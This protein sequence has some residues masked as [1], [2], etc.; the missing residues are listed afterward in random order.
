VRPEFLDLLACP[1]C[2]G[3][4]TL[5]ATHWEEE[6]AMAGELPC[7]GCG[8]RF[9]LTG[10]VPRLGLERTAGTEVRANTARRFAFEWNRFSTFELAEEIASMATWLLPHQPSDLS[11]RTVLDAGCGMGRHMVIA[12]H[13]GAE[14]VVGLDLGDAVDAAFANTRHL[15]GTCVVQGDIYHPPLRDGAFDAAYSLGVLHHL[16][17]P[18]RGFAALAPKVRAGGFFQ[19]WVYGR[20]GNA[21]IVFLLNPIRRLTSRLPLPVLEK[22]CWLAS[23]PLFVALRT[24]YRI[25]RLGQRLPYGGYLTW[26]APFSLR[27]IHAI[28]FDHALAPVAHY[29]TRAEAVAMVADDDWEAP[30]LVHSRGMSWGVGVRRRAEGESGPASGP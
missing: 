11:G 28:V 20:E 7:H 16:P 22:L 6:H 14:R 23:A 8:R 2:S 18:E 10:G 4:L 9:P 3:T 15:P 24:V 27:K 21:W 1:A 30:R 17:D 26:V 5:E 12:C 19:V 29:L 25:P 13:H